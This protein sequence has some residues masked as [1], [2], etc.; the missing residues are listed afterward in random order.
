MQ[1]VP[2]TQA[3]EKQPGMSRLT[4]LVGIAV[5]TPGMA[6]AASEKPVHLPPVTV[7]ENT[8]SV[9]ADRSASVKNTEALVDTPRS[10]AVI[11]QEVIRAT[12]ASE[13][14]EV[15]RTVPGITFSAGEGG[16]PLGDQPFIRGYDAQSS[17]FVDGIRDIGAQSRELFNIESVEV[18]KGPAGAFDGRGSVGGSVSLTSK[19]P[20]LGNFAEGSLALGNANLK[21]ATADGNWQ[22]S[23][24]I[25]ARLNVMGHDADV[26]GRNKVHDLRW[27]VAPSIA[28]GLGTPTRATLSYYHMQADNQ[29]DAG[30]PYNNPTDTRKNARPRPGDGSPVSVPRD[31]YYGLTDRDFRKEQVDTGTL[32][33]EHD[34]NDALKVRNRTRYTHHHQDYIV[35]HPDSIRSGNI[36]YGMVFRRPA[37]RDS[38]THVFT[39]QTDAYGQFATG[40]VKHNYAMGVEF[41]QGAR[42]QRHV[43]RQH[44]RAKPLSQGTGQAQRLQLHHAVRPQSGRPL[45]G[46]DQ[47]QQHAGP[48]D[49]QHR[50]PLSVRLSPHRQP[51]DPERRYPPGPLHRRH[52][53]VELG[54]TCAARRHAGELP[55]RR[56]VQAGAQ[57]Q[58]VPE[59]WHLIQAGRLAAGAGS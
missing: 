19:A 1:R 20:K 50:R 52:H 44:G 37:T 30:I 33:L 32:T 36:Y 22:L 47:A 29:P 18:S 35:T 58:R 21:R 25:A 46:Y 23:D 27:G 53:A 8:E 11:P 5:A 48:H 41:S 59:L 39:N 3:P 15:L 31:T 2:A 9:K 4:G 42:Q 6:V 17:T 55:G 28:F 40:A 38:H 57:R 51:L 54:I 56:A 10:I 24:T 16:N 13:L 7:K 34:F 26:P 49:H 12:A 14:S 45:E 43:Q